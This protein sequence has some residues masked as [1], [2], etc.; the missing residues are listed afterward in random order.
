MKFKS[1]AFCLL[2]VVTGSCALLAAMI[3]NAAEA[4]LP[5]SFHIAQSVPEKTLN[6]I[7]RRSE[8]GDAM[9][10]YIL[11]IP[12]YAAR[13]DHAYAHLFTKNLLIAWANAQAQ[14]VQQDCGGKYLEGEICGI[15]ENPVSCA[16]DFSDKEYL[17]QTQEESGQKAIISYR[18][19]DQA[20]SNAGPKYRLVKSGND[21]KLDGVNCGNGLKFNMN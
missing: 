8:N 15:D 4:G 2:A 17:Y 6:N 13:Q 1:L 9:I 10:D 16:Q 18:W 11:K 7:I 21:W 14:F 5:P 20:T 3:T 12:G 19:A